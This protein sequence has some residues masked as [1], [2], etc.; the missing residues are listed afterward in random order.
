MV[1][2]LGTTYNLGVICNL[3]T[4]LVSCSIVFSSL[5]TIFSKS[6]YYF[7]QVCVLFII[8]LLLMYHA[9][10]FFQ[11]WVLFIAILGTMYNL[12]AILVSC[13]SVI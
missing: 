9:V 6:G 13:T 1:A 10:L 4:N 2:N 8:W 3:V 7:L 12:V 5:G 11:V